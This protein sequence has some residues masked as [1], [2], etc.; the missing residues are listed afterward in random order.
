MTSRIYALLFAPILS[1]G[2]TLA[3]AEPAAMTA[4]A[5]ASPMGFQDE[6]PVQGRPGPHRQPPESFIEDSTRKMA[7]GRVF[8]RRV[9]QTV[10][11]A[12]FSRKEVLTNPDGKTASRTVTA[13]HD[14]AK[15]TW[16]RKMEGVGFDG[17]AW[18]RSD[19]G[20]LPGPKAAGRPAE[21]K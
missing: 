13:R 20:D 15:K 1:V 9:E 19:E 11:E 7:D 21:R 17:K 2:A 10:S 12:G 6:A 8:K 5:D 14:K 3:L 16:S 4:Q 18:S